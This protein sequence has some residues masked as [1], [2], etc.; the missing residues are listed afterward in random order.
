M[1]MIAD[2]V[3]VL[4]F[5]FWIEENVIFLLGNFIQ[6]NFKFFDIKFFRFFNVIF[7]NGCL[8]IQN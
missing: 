3:I 5:S 7:R 6:F 8:K 4:F 1:C 2:V